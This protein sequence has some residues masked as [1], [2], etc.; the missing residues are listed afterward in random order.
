[1]WG[2][3][4]TKA[5]ILG[6]EALWSKKIRIEFH[7]D[8]KNSKLSGEAY[9]ESNIHARIDTYYMVA[10]TIEMQKIFPSNELL[11]DM[12]KER[13]T[14]LFENKLDAIQ[15]AERKEAKEDTKRIWNYDPKSKYCP[16]FTVQLTADNIKALKTT[17]EE[18]LP[19]IQR[20]NEEIVAELITYK[21]LPGKEIATIY[22]V[23]VERCDKH[24][25]EDTY[26]SDEIAIEALSSQQV[27][28]TL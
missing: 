3:S 12:L 4:L 28:H 9:Y 24:G 18:F 27:R 25:F 8:W 6:E 11:F 23:K 10:G 22:N 13:E 15:Y 16:V 2:S 21:T 1:M 17:V 20:N 26:V 14:C 7:E 19:T 5:E